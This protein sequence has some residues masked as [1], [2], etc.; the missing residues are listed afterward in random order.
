[1]PIDTLVLR[2]A[3]FTTLSAAALAGCGKSESP[4]SSGAASKDKAPPAAP[5]DVAAVN[6][7]VPEALKAKLEF[8]KRDIVL[9][10]GRDKMTYTVAAPKGWKHASKMFANLEPES[11]TF[12]M[13][14]KLK[15]NSNCDG[16]CEPKDW[17]AISDKVDFAPYAK[18][19]IVKDEKGKNRR[20]M[21]AEGA[22]ATSAVNVI[23]AWWDD[24]GRNYWTCSAALE[25]D[26]AAAAPAFEKACQ[27]VNIEGDD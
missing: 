26:L 15:V 19:K 2:G 16:A 17:A 7:L 6:A 27:V 24:G 9:E 21:I 20:T 3:L 12:G 4:S 18:G 10:R 13:F 8:E 23:V 11:G 5:I 25:Q 1:M 22:G 14:N